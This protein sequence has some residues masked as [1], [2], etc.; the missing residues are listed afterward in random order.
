MSS[1]VASVSAGYQHSC[2]IMLNSGARCWGDN[3]FGQVGDS[4]N[5]DRLTP[6]TPG[7]DFRN[8]ASIALGDDHTCAVGTGSP[9]SLCWGR[10][11]VGQLGDGTTTNRN[12]PTSGPGLAD[13][14]V[15]GGS[16]TCSVY[17]GAAKCWGFN[18][19]GQIGDGT[20]TNRLTPTAVSGGASAVSTMFAAQDSSCFILT[21]TGVRC[22]G[23]NSEG[24]LGTHNLVQFLVPT[25][26]ARMGGNDTD[27]DD[28]TC[29][30]LSEVF[31]AAVPEEPNDPYDPLDFA[32]IDLLGG[33]VGFADF[34][35]LLQAYG[36]VPT[37]VNW[38]PFAD[39][40]FNDS[41]G[42]SDFLRLLATYNRVC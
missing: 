41:V 23:N 34:L 2:A 20:F 36:S 18:S 5:I 7:T 22:W 1:G 31:N 24:Q 26:V 6:V 8:M 14:I 35:K 42:F 16:H 38:N 30:D 25:N 19:A 28:D 4:T 12:T 10:N 32:N 33:N 13:V 11:N 27:N 15:A 39:V 37:S 9:S 21:S 40:D 17:L 29:S 3:A